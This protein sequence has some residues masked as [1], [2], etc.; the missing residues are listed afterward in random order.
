MMKIGVEEVS[1]QIIQ[2]LSDLTNGTQE[3]DLAGLVEEGDLRNMGMGK[4]Q[5][6]YCVQHPMIVFVHV[7]CRI[8]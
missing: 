6:C 2:K 4:C 8:K 1:K 3:D 5:L 7:K